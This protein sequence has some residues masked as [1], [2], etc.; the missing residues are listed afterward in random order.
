MARTGAWLKYG[1]LETDLRYSS[2]ETSSHAIRYI[3]Y[4][5]HTGAEVGFMERMLSLSN[6]FV[7]MGPGLA[8]VLSSYSGLLRLPHVH[9]SLVVPPNHRYNISSKVH[10]KVFDVLI[11]GRVI[12]GVNIW[13]FD[14]FLLHGQF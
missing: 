2:L 9:S 1:I 10:N 14:H 13:L 11:V 6:Y 4:K 12:V 8:R 3:M 5:S 7:R